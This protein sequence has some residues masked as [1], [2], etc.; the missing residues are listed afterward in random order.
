MS[1]CL[2]YVHHTYLLPL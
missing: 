1:I 2:G